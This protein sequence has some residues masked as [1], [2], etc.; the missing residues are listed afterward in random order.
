MITSFNEKYFRINLIFLLEI[1]KIKWCQLIFLINIKLI[2][3][4]YI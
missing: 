1:K 4:T 2:I 3:F